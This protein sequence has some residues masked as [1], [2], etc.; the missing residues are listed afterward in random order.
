MEALLMGLVIVVPCAGLLIYDRIKERSPRT[1]G[2]SNPR[3]MGKK[4]VAVRRVYNKENRVV[5]G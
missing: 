5:N 2:G 3:A 4:E 1:H